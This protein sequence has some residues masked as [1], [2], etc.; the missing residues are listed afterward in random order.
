MTEGETPN[1][2]W[3]IDAL[4]ENKEQ[5]GKQKKKTEHTPNPATLEHL[6]VSCE[7]HG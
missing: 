7:P 5:N 2:T 4:R 6:V 3:A 1:L